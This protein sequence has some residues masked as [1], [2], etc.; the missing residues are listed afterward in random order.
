MRRLA[1]RQ[2]RT[3]AT[4]AELL[5]MGF[6]TGSRVQMRLLPAKENHGLQFVRT[7]LANRI[8]LP[9][10]ADSVTGTERRTTLGHAPYQV[11]LVEHILSALAAMRVDNCLIELDGPEPPGLDGS[12]FAFVEMIQ[13]AG[14]VLQDAVR[15]RY[16]VDA[17]LLIEQPGATLAIHP[18]TGDE[19]KISYI[20]DY[21]SRS[22]IVPQIHTETI[23]PENYA[24]NLATCRTFVL[25]S[26]AHALQ[27]AGIGK[28]LTP[29]E[30]VVFGSSGV[31]GNQLRFPDEPARHKILDII[32]DLALSGV[33]LVGQVVAYRSGH[34]LNVQMARTIREKLPGLTRV[35]SGPASVRR[36]A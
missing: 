9:A 7:D 28:H 13:E 10:L 11:T 30:L 35:T 6:I 29:A 23:T 26:E 25:E 20:L 34:P 8:S 21:G 2:Q 4:P 1:P 17:P 32:G 16:T 27:K 33:D 12:S 31:I 24:R 3:L 18:S 15:E 19:L 36:A 22:P 14:I 5:G